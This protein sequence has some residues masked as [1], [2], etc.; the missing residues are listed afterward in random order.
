MNQ[1]KIYASLLEIL[2]KM[3]ALIFGSGIR[4]SI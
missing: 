2:E 3:L 1:L 4:L